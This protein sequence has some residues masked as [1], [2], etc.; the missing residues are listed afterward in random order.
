[1]SK[2][3]RYDGNS[4]QFLEGLEMITVNPQMYLGSK[5][6][7]AIKKLLVEIM[8][9]SKDEATP[10]KD[11]RRLKMKVTLYPDGSACVEDNGRG[12]PVDINEK[13]GLPA[14]YLAFEKIHSGAKLRNMGNSFYED[15]IGVHG[16]G[17]SAVNACSEFVNVQVKRDGKIYEVRYRNN[18]K[19]REDLKVIGECSPNETGTKIHFKY[20]SNVLDCTDDEKGELDYPFIVEE[21]DEIIRDYVMFTDNFEA[22]FYWDTG[23]KEEGVEF[24]LRGKKGGKV[25]NKDEYNINNLIKK[26]SNDESLILHYKDKNDELDYKIEILYSFTDFRQETIKLSVVNGLRMILG[27]SQQRAFEDEVFKFFENVFKSTHKIQQGFELTKPEVV[28]KLN[29]IIVLNTSHRDFINQAK[30]S[31]SNDKITMDLREKFRFILSEMP[32][33]V[34]TRAVSAIEFEYKEKIKQ[35]KAY[36][37]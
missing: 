10:L 1:M 17:L 19:E 23:E 9:N 26:Y 24:T 33:E 36:E 11:I 12:I 5:G 3:N 21:I 30:Q 2:N 27:S 6:R 20:D 37:K 31:Y 29:Y 22:E 14:I 13:T 34:I 35:I 8:D 4:F 7:E 15:S 32:S 25:Y 28:N 16:V 18:G